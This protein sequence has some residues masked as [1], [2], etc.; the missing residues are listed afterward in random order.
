MNTNR[1]KIERAVSDL[2]AAELERSW[3]G[4]VGPGEREAIIETLR[5]AKKAY[6]KA[7]DEVFAEPI[8]DDFPDDY[9]V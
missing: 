6:Q 9:E 1:M 8:R 3:A 4:S 2:V 5:T 7:L